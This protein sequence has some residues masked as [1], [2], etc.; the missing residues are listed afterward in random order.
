M[1]LFSL[2]AMLLCAAAC[3]AA[4]DHDDDQKGTLVRMDSKSYGMQGN[5]SKTVAGELLG[6]DGQHNKN[7]DCCARNTFSR[8]VAW[9]TT[10][11]RRT[12]I[13]RALCTRNCAVSPMGN[14]LREPEE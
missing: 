7:Q 11:A 2:Y 13:S 1:K 14:P 5:G 9:C 3:V 10:F 4:K 6:I 8:A 12:T